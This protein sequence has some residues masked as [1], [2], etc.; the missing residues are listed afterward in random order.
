MRAALLV[1]FT[2]AVM[3]LAGC[4]T[5]T[6]TKIVEPER[7]MIMPS[8]RPTLEKVTAEELAPL[9]QETR[10]KLIGNNK[11]LQAWGAEQE[12]E[13]A[14]YNRQAAEANKKNG[15]SPR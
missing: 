3:L 15:Y 9:T 4:G 6:V 8:V 11:K 14:E 13:I 2:L 10:D 12:A 1:G 7:Q 5:V